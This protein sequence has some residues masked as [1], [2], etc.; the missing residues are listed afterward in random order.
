MLTLEFV[1]ILIITSLGMLAF[2]YDYDYDYDH[3]HYPAASARKKCAMI[4]KPAVGH[5]RRKI[6]TPNFSVP[7]DKIRIS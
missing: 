4:S 3:H 7:G 6:L 5:G 1:N 2:D